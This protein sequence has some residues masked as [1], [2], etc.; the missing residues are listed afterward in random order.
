MTCGAEVE[1]GETLET[2]RAGAV[3]FDV[4]AAIVW[5]ARLETGGHTLDERR[6]LAPRNG[7]RGADQS[8]ETA[9]A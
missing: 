7:D 5:A 1:H 9:H 8:D 2:E 6:E 4:R 3:V